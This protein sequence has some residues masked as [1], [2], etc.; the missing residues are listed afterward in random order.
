MGA[1]E[2][3]QLHFYLAVLHLLDRA[4]TALG[5]LD[6]LFGQ[7]PFLAGYN[8]ELARYGMIGRTLQD[9]IG[10]WYEKI[11]RCERES[12]E[13]LPIRELAKAAQLDTATT[14]LLMTAGLAEEDV[15]F[16][17][18]VSSPLLATREARMSARRLLELGL[19]NSSKQ[20]PAP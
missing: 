5:S 11:D 9:A 10:C 20:V 12:D 6:A 4:A 19:L 17:D 8:D 13:H 1:A 18:L 16:A 3:F 14:T 15:R 2:H 7:F